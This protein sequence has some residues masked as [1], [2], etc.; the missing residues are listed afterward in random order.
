MTKSFLIWSGVM[1]PYGFYRQWNSKMPTSLDLYGHRT[2]ASLGNGITYISPFGICKLFNL[3]NRID[4]Y[5]NK[6]DVL[7][8][9]N[10]YEELV[11]RNYD[12]I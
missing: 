8:Y 2:L 7:K 6:H 10:S 12:T 5:I 9:S 1:F 3:V 4:I 11:G